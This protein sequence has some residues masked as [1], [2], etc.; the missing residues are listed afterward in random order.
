MLQLEN[1]IIYLPPEIKV[2]QKG[3]FIKF[4]GSKGKEKLKLPFCCKIKVNSNK[5]YLK[6]IGND[7]LER[8]IKSII[9]NIIQGVSRG[10]GI[11]I[12]LIGTGY[13]CELQ[14][15]TLYFKLGFNHS[16]VM[17]IPEGININILKP[18]H[19]L[20]E[21]SNP[22]KLGQFVSTI[23][24]FRPPEPYKGKGIVRVGEKIRRKQ[25]TKS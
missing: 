25:V 11:E 17:K 23:Q 15:N 3:A 2:C 14:N 8:T 21:G 22:E 10:F 12:I 9:H 4:N 1:N 13:R 5:L 6:M 18:S 20:V 19:F 7:N 24:G 16:V